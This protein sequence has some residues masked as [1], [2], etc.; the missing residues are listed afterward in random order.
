MSTTNFLKNFRG[1]CFL[2]KN[3]EKLKHNFE[4]SVVIDI[5]KSNESIQIPKELGKLINIH[6]MIK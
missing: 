3:V 2:K 1:I 4:S 6:V 5:M